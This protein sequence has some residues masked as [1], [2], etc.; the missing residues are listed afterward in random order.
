[1]TTKKKW[2]L[3]LVGLVTVLIIGIT[4]GSFYLYHF[5]FEPTPKVLTSTSKTSHTTLLKNKAWL[6]KV[7]KQTWHETSATD[8]LKLVADFVPATKKTTRTIVIAHGYMGN[9]EQMASYIRLWHRQ[10]YNVLAPDDRGNGQSQGNYYGFGW[11][12]RL[13][14]VK[15]TKQIV[16]RL[17]S[18]SQIGLFGV[19]MGGATVMMMSGEKL[20]SQV[21]AII[22]DCGYTSVTDE[23][24]Y[25]LKQLY[26]LPKFP[27]IYT[28]SWVADWKAHFNFLEA[29]SV[30]QLKKN[31]LPI[32]FIHGADDT[33]VPT[34]MVYENYRA[35]TVKDK[36]L[37]VVPGAK[38][39]EALNKQP[40][41]YE[42][43]V[44]VFMAS[45]MK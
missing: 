9:K 11:P 16:R 17:G 31:K 41:Q 14:Y 30:N 35:T 24:A 26:H 19:S 4:G 43:K 27:L 3:V 45:H 22:E 21:K 37:W 20:P 10:G 36:K 32:F 25:E 44:A 12:D 42:E 1:M 23:L 6:K 38:H 34:K 15:W 2:I 7:N 18:D 39:G 13:D 40:D 8:H 5:A 33:F 29:S 28:A